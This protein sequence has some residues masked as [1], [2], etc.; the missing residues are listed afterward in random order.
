[1]EADDMMGSRSGLSIGYL[2]DHR[3]LN[4]SSAR[5]ADAA[6]SDPSSDLVIS[7]GTPP[8]AFATPTNF[9]SACSRAVTVNAVPV[10]HVSTVVVA[11][12]LNG[13]DESAGEG[14]SREAVGRF[15]RYL[16]ETKFLIWP[17]GRGR[18]LPAIKADVVQ[19]QAQGGAGGRGGAAWG[20]ERRYTPARRY[21]VHRDV[22]SE[23]VAIAAAK[24]CVRVGLT[25]ALASVCRF[26]AVMDIL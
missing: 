3:F 24:P 6:S 12:S 17:T 15:L 4:S 20:E 19:A 16:A 11:A 21:V 10:G 5:R 2:I 23:T 18:E 25:R 22:E 14:I 13:V 1:M 7:S 8:L 9:S 26:A